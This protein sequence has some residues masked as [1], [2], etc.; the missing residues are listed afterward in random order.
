MTGT[1]NGD[2]TPFDEDTP[3]ATPMGHSANRELATAL[4][5]YTMALKE[6]GRRIDTLYEFLRVLAF[7]APLP[8]RAGLVEEFD[9]HHGIEGDRI[10]D[11][12]LVVEK[13]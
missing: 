2:G 7:P 6:H 11:I 9:R 5:N 12:R 3:P 4:G 8:F 10:E 13:A 1:G